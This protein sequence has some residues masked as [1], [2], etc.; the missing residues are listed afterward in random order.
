MQYAYDAQDRMLTASENGSALLATYDYDDLGRRKSVQYGAAKAKVSYTFNG[1]SDLLTLGHDF[2][3]SSDVTYTYT[4][5]RQIADATITNAAFKYVPPAANIGLCINSSPSR[6]DRV[7]SPCGGHP[8]FAVHAAA[9]A[10]TRS[11]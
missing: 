1:E 5:A 6:I 4:P 3:A 7:A 2:V 11:R 8:G 10:N 9:G